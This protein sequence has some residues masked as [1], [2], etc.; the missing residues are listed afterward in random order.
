MALASLAVVDEP[1]GASA[2][3]EDCTEQQ[4]DRSTGWK[5]EHIGH[6]KP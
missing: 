3:Q 1:V 5:I 4:H 2:E 6:I